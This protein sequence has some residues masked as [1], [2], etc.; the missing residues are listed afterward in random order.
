MVIDHKCNCPD[1][2]LLIEHTKIISK[3]KFQYL[4]YFKLN[5]ERTPSNSNIGEGNKSLIIKQVIFMD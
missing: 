4:K 3:K 1:T 2:N 5:V